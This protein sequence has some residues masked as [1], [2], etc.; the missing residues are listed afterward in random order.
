MG[1][2]GES[3]WPAVCVA[4]GGGFALAPR[5]AQRPTSADGSSLPRVCSVYA[6]P[7]LVAPCHTVAASRHCTSPARATPLCICCTTERGNPQAPVRV[8]FVTTRSRS[9]Q[10]NPDLGAGID[11]IAVRQQGQ[12]I[13]GRHPRQHVARLGAGPL[14][15]VATV[16]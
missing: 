5:S 12:A 14:A 11:A 10:E 9:E 1:A 8:T 15:A 6:G 4:P 7:A 16:V 13:G 2:A 3:G